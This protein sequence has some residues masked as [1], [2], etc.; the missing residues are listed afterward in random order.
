MGKHSYIFTGSKNF[1]H[2]ALQWSHIPSLIGNSTTY[3]VASACPYELQQ[4]FLA[5]ENKNH[6]FKYIIW[7]KA[8]GNMF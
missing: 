6:L 3:E 7:L 8:W 2:L 1:L 4:Q 5:D